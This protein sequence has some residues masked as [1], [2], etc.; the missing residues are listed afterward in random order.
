MGL[1]VWEAGHATSIEHLN[2]ARGDAVH[3][4][5]ILMTPDRLLCHAPATKLVDVFSAGVMV[6]SDTTSGYELVCEVLGRIHLLTDVEETARY[7]KRSLAALKGDRT[8]FVSSMLM[9]IN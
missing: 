5:A 9:R 4:L 2:F 6:V 7:I 1:P 8:H 3:G